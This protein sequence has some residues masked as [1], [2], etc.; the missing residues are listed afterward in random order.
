MALMLSGAVALFAILAG[1]IVAAGGEVAI[2]RDYEA[3]GVLAEPSPRN[4]SQEEADAK[5]AGCMSCHTN[6]DE[7]SMH[8]TP[9]VILGCTDCHGG[10]PE[11]ALADTQLDP[12]DPAYL[13]VQNRAHVLPLYPQAWHWPGSANP[14]RSYTLLNRESP[15]Y[16]RFVNPSDYRVVREACGSCH[17]EVIEAAERSL[18]ATGAMLWGGAAYNNGI[19]PFKVYING[20]AYTRD[21]EPAALASPRTAPGEDGEVIDPLDQSRITEAHAERGALPGLV[22]LPTWHVVP[23]GDIFRVFERGGRN[24]NSQFPEIGIP[25]IGG[26]IQRLE[27]N[28]RPD[29]RQSNRGRGTGLRVSIPVLNIHKTRLNDPFTWFMGTSEQ[30]G[31][32]RHS[33]CASCHVVYAN[34]REPRHSLTYSQFGRDGQT[35]TVDPTINR[36]RQGQHRTNIE[37]NPTDEDSQEHEVDVSMRPGQCGAAFDML[38]RRLEEQGIRGAGSTHHGEPGDHH[39]GGDATENEDHEAE[40]HDGVGGPEEDAAE[41]GHGGMSEVPMELRERGH[42]LRHAFTRAIPTSQCMSCHMHQPNVFLNSFLG[43]TMWDYES[44]AP[45]MWPREQVYRTAEQMFAILDRNPEMA[46]VRGCWGDIDFVRNVTDL[47]NPQA[48]NT[49]FADYHSHGWNFRGIFRR[50]REGNMLDED[51]NIL[52]PDDPELFRGRRPVRGG[53]H[54]S[55]PRRPYDGYPC[56]TRHAVRGLPFRAGQP[57]QRPDLWRGRERDRNQLPRLPR[58]RRRIS[59]AQD[60]RPGRAADRQQPHADAQPGRPAPLRMD[61]RQ[62]GTPYP[63]PAIDHRSRSRMGGEPCPR[64]RRPHPPR[65]Q[66]GFGAR[67]ADGPQRRRNRRVRIRPRRCPRR[68]RPSR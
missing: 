21:S 61:A 24:I 40:S 59:D 56:R 26:N 47:I 63:R 33:G 34:D 17:I 2:P 13:A 39:E 36:L 25:N 44:D 67:Q 54:Q 30:P 28:G 42:P 49:Q 50:D 53:R 35:I 29:L 41:S 12:D 68:P 55:G 52:D 64:Q 10:N 8:A 58:H 9:A 31:D 60:V 23:P 32:Y 48:R 18:M 65:F 37:G 14:A 5:S 7:L 51:G 6:T 62:C 4:Q 57:W 27:E 15:E 1:P 19:L 20:E 22:P 16:I 45:L 11:V 46:S 38:A 3:A 66:R 43:Y